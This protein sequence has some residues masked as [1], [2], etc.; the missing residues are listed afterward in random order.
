MQRQIALKSALIVLLSLLLLIPLNMIEGQIRARSLYLDAVKQDIATSWTGEQAVMSPVLVQP[1]QVS[2]TNKKNPVI[3]RYL[4]IPAR[5]LQIAADARSEM[6]SRGIYEV[7]VYTSELQ[8][9]GRIM[10]KNWHEQR[11]KVSAQQNFESFLPPYLAM[12]LSDPRGVGNSFKATLNGR[13]AE[14][15][16]GAGIPLLENG[17][18]VELPPALL[19]QGDYLEFKLQFELRGMSKL[20]F[21]P[22]AESVNLQMR[23]D[24]QHPKFSGAFLPLEHEIDE[25]GFRAAWSVNEFSSAAKNKLQLCQGGK[26]AALLQTQ[27]SVEFFQPV[28]IYQQAERA[29]KY[30]VLFIAISFVSFFIFEALTTVRIH[31]IQYTLVGLSL[32]IF[33]LLLI[34]LSEH[35]VFLWAYLIATCACTLLLLAYLSKVL[36]KPWQARIFCGC[37]AG[38]HAMLYVILQLEDFALL[39]GAMLLF[40]LLAILMLATRTIDWYAL[41]GA[42][43]LGSQGELFE[44]SI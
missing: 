17:F 44:K 4:L 20:G 7:P 33:Y 2:S 1:Y 15:V 11:D 6:R 27:L 42:G 3:I 13:T 35:M 26:C 34:S 39:M 37:L 19:E 31:P 18:R 32:A 29:V 12:Y 43:Q 21:I 36:A 14:L 38:L 25:V 24:W 10:Q 16:P 40:V 30:G 9:D 8:F 23:S 28:D 5:H 22:A 41:P